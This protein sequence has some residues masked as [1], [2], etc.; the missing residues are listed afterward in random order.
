VSTVW[1]TLVFLMGAPS[2]PEIGPIK[3][4]RQCS[5]GAWFETP[6]TG[7]WPQS[8]CTAACHRA[9][10]PKPRPKRSRA[11]FAVSP[12]QRDAVRGR[13]CVVCRKQPVHPA[14]LIDRS[15]ADDQ[16]NPLAV[17]PLCPEHHRA[18]D[19]DRLDLLPFLEPHWR[20]QLAFAVQRHGLLA[21]LKRVTNHDWTPGRER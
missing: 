20:D 19:E 11:A 15:L 4:N 21:T 14:H 18:F 8:F 16:D 5:C 6:H 9:S 13:A 3:R 10:K 7:D 12:L 1:Y 2:T 17:I